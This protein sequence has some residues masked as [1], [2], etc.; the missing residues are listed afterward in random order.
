MAWLPSVLDCPA[1]TS[2]PGAGTVA[3]GIANN[4]AR[5]RPAKGVMP[6]AAG[7]DQERWSA[8]DRVEGFGHAFSNAL[9]W[10]ASARQPG[11]TRAVPIDR[12]AGG[13]WTFGGGTV[14]ILLLIAAAACGQNVEGLIAA[15]SHPD[16]E[17]RSKASYQLV[18]MGPT[19]VAPLVAAIDSGSDSLRYIAAQILGRIG[20]GRAQPALLRLSQDPHEHVRRVAL[21]ALGGMADPDLIEYLTP[22][23]LEAALPELRAAA[24]QGLAGLGDTAA[25]RPLIRTLDDSSATV[26]KE[27]VVALNRL[28][29]PMAEDAIARTLAG[30][31][32]ETVRYVAVQAL[33]QRQGTGTLLHLSAALRDSS[34]W[35]RTE[36]AH[37]LRELGDSAAV[38]ALARLLDRRQG[39]DYDA[40]VLALRALETRND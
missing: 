13:R 1:L 5:W 22:V 24:A 38:G 27:A 35:V 7:T 3:A 36:A 23:L 39:P 20:D 29:T 25:V 9:I 37:G 6:Q 28:W 31:A 32:N 34:V 14:R 12:N 18:K 30:D 17:T 21:V 4:R 19:A 10:L 15:L 11:A 8:E 40:A 33:A 16:R 26:R 2:T